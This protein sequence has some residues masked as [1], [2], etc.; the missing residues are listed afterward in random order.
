VKLQILYFY[1]S[2]I[3]VRFR[4][5]TIRSIVLI[6]I[7]SMIISVTFHCSDMSRSRAVCL[8]LHR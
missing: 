5:R 6:D 4:Y 1:F 7:E 8:V 2:S 3:L